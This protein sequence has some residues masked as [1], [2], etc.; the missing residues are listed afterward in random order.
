MASTVGGTDLG[1]LMARVS[2]G[3]RIPFKGAFWLGPP[4]KFDDFLDRDWRLLH[5]DRAKQIFVHRPH[6]VIKKNKM[7]IPVGLGLAHQCVQ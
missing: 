1:H 6:Q 3:E 7:P 5:A 2:R 4:C